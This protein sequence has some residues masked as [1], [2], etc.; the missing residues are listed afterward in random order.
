MKETTSLI[1]LFAFLNLAPA[2]CSA[3]TYTVTDLGALRPDYISIGRGVNS[4]GQV[5]G[6]SGHAFLYDG[7]LHD[8]GT[9]G[10]T[11]SF[12]WGINGSGQV[13]G[14]AFLTFDAAYHAFLYD[15]MIHDLGTLGGSSSEGLGINANG[16]VTGF[17]LT[18]GDAAQHAYLY[19]SAHGMVDLNSLISPSSGWTL[20]EGNAINDSG[21][22]TG[23][24]TTGDATHAFLL[25]PVPEPNT[26]AL[27]GLGM[28]GA[29]GYIRRARTGRLI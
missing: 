18:T 3:T 15:G 19:D 17:S 12:A 20:Y 23:F 25:T 11:Y 9:F 21:Q 13:A 6:D 2:V 10:G 1:A 5:T 8:L 22:I 29:L 14:T 4:S 28:I 16:Q 26:F 24:G 7:T 27:A